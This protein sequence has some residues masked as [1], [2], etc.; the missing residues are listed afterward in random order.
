MDLQK[1]LGLNIKKDY[2]LPKYDYVNQWG[3]YS[4]D[5]DN[6]GQICLLFHLDFLSPNTNPFLYEKQKLLQGH[7][8]SSITN[9]TF[10]K[11]HGWT[12][13]RNIGY[14]TLMM[15]LPGDNIMESQ[16]TQEKYSFDTTCILCPLIPILFSM[17]KSNWTEYIRVQVSPIRCS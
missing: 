3:K 14:H 16:T 12:S 6:P 7:K 15:W 11:P 9:R 10:K 5:P 13:I 8:N 2:W 4:G 1:P 17:K